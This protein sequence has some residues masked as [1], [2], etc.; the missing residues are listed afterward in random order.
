MIVDTFAGGL[1]GWDWAAR[2]LGLN[3]PLGIEVDADACATRAAAGLWTL[4]ADVS[5]LALAPFVGKVKGI[6]ASPPCQS[7]SVAG[8]R[9]GLASDGGQ[10][11][12]EPLRWT[13]E[14]RPEWLACEQV[15]PVLPIWRMIADELRTLGYSAWCGILDSA[16]YGT[17]QNRKRAILMASRVR[18][19]QPP[20]P[21]H[22]RTGGGDMFGGQREPWV[23]MS[24]ALGWGASNRPAPTICGKT[25]GAG[26]AHARVILRTG[27]NTSGPGERYERE[28]ER[29]APCVTGN[30]DQ[31]S[32][33]S[34]GRSYTAPPR[35][36]PV[37]EPA[38]TV[39]LGHNLAEWCWERPSTT[40]QCDVR[41][42]RPGH[43]GDISQMKDSIP[44]TLGDL[45]V[46]QDAP[47]DYPLVGT[48]ESRAR[49]VG[50]GIPRRLASSV[51]GALTG[52]AMEAVA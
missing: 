14:L 8:R 15:P 6:T 10:L 16:D 32:L 12:W 18:A 17:P 28:V 43:H 31:W 7:W 41:I 2:D 21:T 30:A 37:T 20:E 40:V 38:P 52:S 23:T 29:P 36:A 46:L 45:L 44:V 47:P 48:Q 22:S 35:R 27:Q 33:R 49:I 25:D 4:R 24:D 11:V 19:V 3:D 1:A 51:L 5:T 34:P 26:G 39:A 50:N 42:S 9:D 13:K